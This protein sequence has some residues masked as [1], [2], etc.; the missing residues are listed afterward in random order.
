MVSGDA[1]DVLGPL[2]MELMNDT[3]RYINA[4]VNIVT[5]CATA[6]LPLPIIHSLEIPR[7]QKYILMVV[8]AIGLW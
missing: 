6:L 2:M 8:F 1:C 5:D 4:G 7:K 3:C